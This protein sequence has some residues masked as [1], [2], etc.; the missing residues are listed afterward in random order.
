MSSKAESKSLNYVDIMF[1][2]MPIGVALYNA[3]DLR[4]LAANTLMLTILDT[5]LDP[6]WQGQ[7]V[8]HPATDWLPADVAPSLVAICR[9]VVETGNPF[10]IDEYA[11]LSPGRGIT[12]WK[13]DLHPVRDSNGH[14]TQLLQTVSEVT[15][16]VL[17]RQQAEQTSASLSQTK[18]VVEA[19]R[20]RLE[21]IETIA[22]SVR[23]SLDTDKIAQA[24]IAAITSSFE[25]LSTSIH[26]A[27][28]EQQVLHLLHNRAAQHIEQETVALL[29]H[30]PYTS[31][32][33]VARAPQHH[34]PIIIEDVQAAARAGEIPGDHPIVKHGRCG[35]VC[36]PLWFKDFEGTLSVLFKE[37]VAQDSP[38]VQTLVGCATHL[39]AAL[40][41]ARL[42]ATVENE[43][44][45]L[46]AVLDQLPEGVLLVEASDSGVSYVNAAATHV[47][48]IPPQNEKTRKTLH[49]ISQVFLITDLQGHSIPPEHY[50]V[51]RS[52]HGETISG[53]EM[54]LTRLDGSKVVLLCSAAPLQ[55]EDGVISGA[56]TVFQDIT[57]RKSFEQ[58]KNEF[59]S[60]VSHELRTP[61][62]AIQGFAE[63]LQ[64]M[65][66]SGLSLESPRGMRIATGIIEQSERLTQLIE[67]MLD[68]TRIENVQLLL[69]L[70]PHD[71]L[72]TLTHLVETQ[73]VTTR[74]HH[75]Q[76]VLDELQPTDVL[77]G[78]FDKK[79][80]EQVINNLISNAIKYSP[81]G[82]EIELGLHPI[83]DAASI[84][85][86]ALIWVRDPG[87]GI[88]ANELP[89]I[90]E[91]F[92]RA[93]NLDRAITGL[94]IG[95]YLTKEL[96][97]RHG[98]RIWAKSTEGMGAT[99][100]VSLP[101]GKRNLSGKT[102]K[103]N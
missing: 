41:H 96:V 20:S 65:V 17:A 40:A 32:L 66:A 16:H 67:E 57:A 102:R 43:R 88:P 99:F 15:S 87:I 38:E 85:Y 101:L 6:C 80:I 79:R 68:L 3:Q 77:I 4:L 12:Y 1:E 58:Q 11:F 45:R 14:I 9:T 52:L 72:G 91:R 22:R 35:Y 63:I 98:G 59:L 78:Y 13:W 100:F 70:A 56:V 29:Q 30:V 34:E 75:L 51:S 64:M 24:A 26:I 53:Q 95:L 10:H 44:A 69:D 97:E 19:E 49:Q 92:H 46:R 42:H 2:H 93:S 86:E 23:E 76:L 74:K 60:I 82:G 54:V 94:G 36:I 89:H 73:A 37:T 50:P 18:Q 83:L 28:P 81:Y 61:I 5:N 21:V 27:D 8:G 47:I 39:A 31:Q 84:P 55:T 25:P 71:L 90:F 48:G 103:E 7:M 33:I 62:T